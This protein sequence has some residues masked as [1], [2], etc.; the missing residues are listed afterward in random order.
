QSA[1]AA[2]RG[3]SHRIGIEASLPDGLGHGGAARLVGARRKKLNAGDVGCATRNR[4][5]D[6]LSQIGEAANLGAGGACVCEAGELGDLVFR[7]LVDLLEVVSR[8]EQ[9]AVGQSEGVQGIEDGAE[10]PRIL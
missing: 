5:I 3:A 6:H 7:V 4:S 1:D 10:P 2:A 9:L 8:S